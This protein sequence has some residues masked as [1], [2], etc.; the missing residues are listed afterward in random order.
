M[1]FFFQAAI[2][3]H[4]AIAQALVAAGADVAVSDSSGLTPLEYATSP[5]MSRLLLNNS[6]PPPIWL[7]AQTGDMQGLVAGNHI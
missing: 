5:A 4:P 2:H 3:D 1:R 7:A 6:P